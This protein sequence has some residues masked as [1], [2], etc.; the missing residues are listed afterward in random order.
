MSTPTVRSWAVRGLTRR[1]RADSSRSVRPSKDGRRSVTTATL[2]SAVRRQ[3]GRTGRPTR[4]HGVGYCRRSSASQTEVGS[5]RRA[6]SVSRLT[7]P[8]GYNGPAAG[9]TRARHDHVRHGLV[10]RGRR[11][12]SGRR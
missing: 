7:K 8:T 10:A 9:S 11:G 3:A 2:P 5:T 6:P 4:G 12:P 1:G